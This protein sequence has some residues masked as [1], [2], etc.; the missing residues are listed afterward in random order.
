LERHMRE[1]NHAPKDRPEI[2]D[3]KRLV[4]LAYTL[5]DLNASLNRHIDSA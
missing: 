3:P 2:V 5:R 4:S 1:I